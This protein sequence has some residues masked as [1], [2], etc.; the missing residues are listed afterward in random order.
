S[1]VP[2]QAE[3]R[4][5]RSTRGEIRAYQSGYA[6]EREPSGR[7]T[8]LLPR[9]GCRCRAHGTLRVLGLYG[10]DVPHRA[11]ED[12]PHGVPVVAPFWWLRRRQ[13]EGAGVGGDCISVGAR[14]V[15]A[16]LAVC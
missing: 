3:G 11:Q 14:F 2:L 8:G 6:S 7:A 10:R 15:I 12:A 13:S 5:K 4:G 16:F 9:V 1:R